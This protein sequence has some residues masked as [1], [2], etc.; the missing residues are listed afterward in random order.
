MKAVATTKSEPKLREK[1]RAFVLKLVELKREAMDL[2]LV[3]T[4]HALDGAT[5]AVG[6]EIAEDER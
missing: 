4:H 5:D 2:G 6:W 1:R 3:K